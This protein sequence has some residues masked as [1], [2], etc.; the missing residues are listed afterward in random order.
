[1]N[2]A[3]KFDRRSQVFFRLLIVRTFSPNQLL[4]DMFNF[5]WIFDLNC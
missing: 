4:M 3:R 1:M 5:D 2:F